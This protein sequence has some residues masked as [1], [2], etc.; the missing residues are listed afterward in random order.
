MI[1]A[2]E[3]LTMF[4]NAGNLSPSYIIT[5][6]DIKHLETDVRTF[7]KK[8]NPADIFYLRP[9]DDNI[10]VEATNAFI[11]QSHLSP[12]GSVKIMIITD[13]AMMS[14]IAQNKILKTL[15]D[16]PANTTFILMAEQISMAIDTVIS[17][18][19]HISIPAP[20]ISMADIE[21]IESNKEADAIERG[22]RH[23]I[24]T[25]KK[26]DDTLGYVGLI[27]H[28]D[29]VDLTLLYIR[30]AI[31]TA[32]S[33]RT[34]SPQKIAALTTAMATIERNIDAYCNATNAMDLILIT[35]F[36]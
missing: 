18:C 28:K 27:T 8:I 14:P 15:E 34:L 10:S 16:A 31:R 22:V 25:A 24:H 6:P 21:L 36:Q 11:A 12:V 1:T 2:S 32:I 30:R 17:R 13:L 20:A 33:D 23:L 26:L 7:T 29:N 3:R 5:C 9:V 35:L 4:H 19:V